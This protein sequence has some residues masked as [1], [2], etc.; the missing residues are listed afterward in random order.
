MAFI[1]CVMAP[2]ISSCKSNSLAFPMSTCVPNATDAST[3]AVILCSN[4]NKCCVILAA[5]WKFNPKFFT[6]ILVSIKFL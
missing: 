5:F 2:A 3:S 1:I 4:D 6:C